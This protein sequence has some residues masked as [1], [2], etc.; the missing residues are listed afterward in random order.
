MMPATPLPELRTNRVV[1]RA[2]QPS[3]IG[4]WH[5]AW[6]NDPE[7]V[8][9]S[10]QRFVA[11]TQDS[12]E[13]YRA[14]FDGSANLYA[15]ARLAD[16]GE[17]I[18]S[19]TAYRNL[20]H[21]T[22]DI[23]ILIGERRLWGQGYGFEAFALLSAWLAVTPGLRKLSCGTLACN[24][25]MISIAERCGYHRE[26][27]RSAQELVDGEPVDIVHFARFVHG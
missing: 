14:G 19:L 9:W 1:L 11:H 6:L 26:A 21:G 4:P 13:R 15:S 2:M 25:G 7:V 16:S 10:N 20:H 18:G 27:V 24:H 22:A 8:R 12:C 23:G 17:P 5:V 3:D